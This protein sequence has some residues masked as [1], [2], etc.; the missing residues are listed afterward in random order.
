MDKEYQRIQFGVESKKLRFKTNGGKL[1]EVNFK[2]HFP[3]KFEFLNAEFLKSELIKVNFRGLEGCTVIENLMNSTREE[4][5]NIKVILN[6]IAKIPDRIKI[7]Y[8]LA[9]VSAN[10]KENF[11]PDTAGGGILVGN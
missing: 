10:C 4:S 1:T 5:K 7:E 3:D 9:E 6:D 11:V 8:I 2:I